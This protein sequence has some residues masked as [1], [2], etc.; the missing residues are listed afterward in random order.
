MALNLHNNISLVYCD[1]PGDLLQLA[2]HSFPQFS[3]VELKMVFKLVS[4]AISELISLLEALPCIYG[5]Y[6]LL[7]FCF[8]LFNLLLHGVS[9]KNLDKYR[10]NYF[11]LC[12]L[13]C[14]FLVSFSIF[15]QHY[16]VAEE[17]FPFL[18]HLEVF[19]MDHFVNAVGFVYLPH[20][21]CQKQN[22][23]VRGLKHFKVSFVH[24][25]QL[26]CFLYRF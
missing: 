7:N 20:T 25:T 11:S 26:S 13:T 2:F 24:F 8:S 5:V 14:Y 18:R 12:K 9:A 16:F 15:L 1:F 17:Y 22:D 4:S 19:G 3:Y 23:W 6:M 21:C 10:E